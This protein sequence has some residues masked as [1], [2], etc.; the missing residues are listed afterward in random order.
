M[1]STYYED[2][3]LMIME[4]F[5]R[6]DEEACDFSWDLDKFVIPFRVAEIR[7]PLWARAD[8]DHGASLFDWRA[9]AE[10]GNSNGTPPEDPS[11]GP[12]VPQARGSVHS[13]T[14]P[15]QRKHGQ[16]QRLRCIKS[17]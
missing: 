6:V 10:N 2:M 13:R 8:W 16:P 1:L 7:P 4:G 3:Q 17:H 11:R 9:I 15:P 12:H 5:V 14:S